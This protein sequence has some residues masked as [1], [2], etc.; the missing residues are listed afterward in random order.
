LTQAAAVAVGGLISVAPVA[1]GVYVLADP[2]TKSDG[3]PLVRLAPLSAVS[4]DQPQPFRAIADLADAW[5]RFPQ[6]VIGAVYLRIRDDGTVQALSSTCPHLG[7]YVAYNDEERQFQCPCHTS[8]FEVDGERVL[9]CV[10]P[11][12]MDELEVEIR[13][14]A[15]WVRFQKFKTGIDE[16]KPKA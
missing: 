2:L 9:P 3:A 15:V 12:A 1:A 10:S 7:C 16:K 11:R 8:K 13:D 14:D 5:N 6:Q 4:A